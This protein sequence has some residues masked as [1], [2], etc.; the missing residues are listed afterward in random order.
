MLI[1]PQTRRARYNGREL[2]LTRR[3][4]DLLH[5]LATHEGRMLIHEQLRHHIRGDDFMGDENN[6]I[7]ISVSRL[8]QKLEGGRFIESV[9]GIGYRFIDPKNKKK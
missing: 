4:F 7:P 9:R 2:E 3:E 1:N 8:R 5:L 6:A